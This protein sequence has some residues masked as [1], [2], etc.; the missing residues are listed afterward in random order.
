[1]FKLTFS[2]SFDKPESPTLC[3]SFPRHLFRKVV[4]RLKKLGL[5][6]YDY[7]YEKGRV[8]MYLDPKPTLRAYL[9]EKLS[10]L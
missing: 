10:K 1:M 7:S 3:L 4:E 2:H 6:E 8:E 9:I 5:E